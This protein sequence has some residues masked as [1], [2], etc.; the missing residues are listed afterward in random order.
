MALPDCQSFIDG[1]RLS[2]P[3]PLRPILRQQRLLH[4]HRVCHAPATRTAAADELR[5][6][7]GVQQDLRCVDKWQSVPQRKLGGALG[8]ESRDATGGERSF[9]W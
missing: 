8:L 1:G 5:S 2:R 9:A 4:T 6:L 3:R 7:G